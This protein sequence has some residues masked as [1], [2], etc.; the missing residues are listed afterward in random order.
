MG[1]ITTRN[2]TSPQSQFHPLSLWGKGISESV[3]KSEQSFLNVSREKFYI[4]VIVTCLKNAFICYG[5]SNIVSPYTIIGILVTF[6]CFQLVS[7]IGNYVENLSFI[8]ASW[9]A[10]LCVN[11][12]LLN[13]PTIT[14]YSISFIILSVPIAFPV[15]AQLIFLID[16]FYTVFM[17]LYMLDVFWGIH[18]EAIKYIFALIAG[19]LI[20]LSIDMHLKANGF[21]FETIVVSILCFPLIKKAIL[22]GKIFNAVMIA[23]LLYLGLYDIMFRARMQGINLNE[24]IG[25]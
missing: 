21:L 15:R 2:E 20:A 18:E 25:F 4:Y 19:I 23:C 16:I 24:M 13:L 12:R 10:I 3:T 11:S 8:W 14:R 1:N 9:T 5:M 7:L 6:S 22:G 17:I